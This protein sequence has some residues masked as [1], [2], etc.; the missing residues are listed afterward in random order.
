MLLEPPVFQDNGGLCR[1]YPPFPHD[2]QV[3]WLA[4]RQGKDPSWDGGRGGRDAQSFLTSKEIHP[5][6]KSEWQRRQQKTFVAFVSCATYWSL[7]TRYIK[8]CVVPY[9]QN[10]ARCTLMDKK[11]TSLFILCKSIFIKMKVDVG[12][13][14]RNGEEIYGEYVLLIWWIYIAYRVLLANHLCI[15]VP[16]SICFHQTGEEYV[17]TIEW[18]VF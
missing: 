16:Y 11:G 14:N 12:N 6:L 4:G 15:N 3:L 10:P 9:C 17:S 18:I 13:W 2:V 8:V 7:S 5:L 1:A